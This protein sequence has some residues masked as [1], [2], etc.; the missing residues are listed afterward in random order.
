MNPADWILFKNHVDQMGERTHSAFLLEMKK[1]GGIQF[2]YVGQPVD[3]IVLDYHLGKIVGILNPTQM[4]PIK[5][6]NLDVVPNAPPEV[7]T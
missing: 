2:T 5:L 4:E 7:K 3:M 6:K 1:E